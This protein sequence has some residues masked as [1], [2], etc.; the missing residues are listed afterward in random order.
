M[1]T[2]AIYQ[3]K[4]KVNGKRYI[5]STVDFDMRKR[6][7]ASMLR[8]GSHHSMVLQRAFSKYGEDAFEYAIIEG[9]IQEQDLIRREQWFID[10][11]CPEYNSNKVAG[12]PP[13][14]NTHS[15]ESL[16][17]RAA[18]LHKPILQY[19]IDS[20]TLRDR[21]G[22]LNVSMTLIREWESIAAASKALGIGNPSISECCLGIHKSA[23]GFVFKFKDNHIQYSPKLMAK[24]S[25]G[26]RRQMTANRSSRKYQIITPS[27]D[28]VVV[29]G[30]N[31]YCKENG[32]N[33]KSAYNLASGCKKTYR[34]YSIARIE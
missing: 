31:K 2:G 9:G 17:K 25:S 33:V 18:A 34:G 6:L 26:E 14:T 19:R 3:I 12:K 5:G 7:H 15:E 23:G 29:H 13:P 10:S 22:R 1:R 30:L 28:V 16:R 8:K 11:Q 32:L 21:S 24:L 20:G 4:N 27:G